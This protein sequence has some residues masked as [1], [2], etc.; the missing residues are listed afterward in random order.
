MVKIY[1][2]FLFNNELDML[3]L[4]LSE[5]YDHVDYFIIGE[6]NRSFKGEPKPYNLL[7]NW[8]RFKPWADKIRRIQIDSIPHPDPWV[9]EDLDREFL[10]HG[11]HD[12]E[13]WDI[14]ICSDCDEILSSTAL[15]NMRKLTQYW[16]FALNV[17]Q[18]Y[19]RLNYLM[20]EWSTTDGYRVIWHTMGRA[21]RYKYLGEINGMRK[22]KGH[23]NNDNEVTV[24]HAGWHFSF[25]GDEQFVYQKLKTFDYTWL[26]EFKAQTY[27]LDK[28][29]QENR[30]ID[31][32]AKF[33]LARVNTYFPQTVINNRERWDKWIIQRDNLRDVRN[34]LN[35]RL[36]PIND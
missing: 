31:N 18:F 14:I 23:Q 27:D 20:T 29:I 17:P 28:C 1:D 30:W 34:I 9:N 25:M 5:M 35:P 26:G 22:L 24:W 11:L 3:E 4:H 32:D 36:A 15:G 12:A 16:Y 13:E 10:K 6:A 8:E 19:Y 21:P 7:D 33:E 2:C